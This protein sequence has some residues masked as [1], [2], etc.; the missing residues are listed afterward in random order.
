VHPALDSIRLI[1]CDLDGTLVNSLPD[2]SHALDSM[3]KEAG[4]PPAGQEKAAVWIG[5]G[6]RMLV[7]RALVDAG[8]AQGDI[9][10]QLDRYLA[11]FDSHYAKHVCD[12]SYVYEG[13]RDFLH[14][15]REA[16]FLFAI[17]TNKPS[18]FVGPILETLGID[19]IFDVVV[20][21]DE[22]E[23]KK[24]DPVQLHHVCDVLGIDPESCLMVG[25]SRNDIQAAKSVPMRSLAV[26][27]GYNHGEPIELSDPDWLVES[28]E[29]VV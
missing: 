2:L 5:N 21:G 22:L 7:R 4:F 19:N 25:D 17:V 14:I 16:G 1:I 28:L 27:Y 11:S 8:L 24:P 10:A 13:V 12:Q 18:V 29:D 23:A 6:T 9:D 26:T 3:L 20:G 15:N